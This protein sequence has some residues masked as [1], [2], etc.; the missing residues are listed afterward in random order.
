VLKAPLL[1]VGARTTYLLGPKLE[2][3]VATEPDEAFPR[4]LSVHSHS[5]Y[6]QTWFELGLVGATLLTLLGLAISQA[7]RSLARPIQPYAYATFVSAVVMAAS[8]Y[9]MWQT[10]F[11]SLFGITAAMFALGVALL[12]GRRSGEAAAAR[13]SERE[14]AVG[15]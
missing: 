11:V 6:L 8:S 1:G 10:W 2:A 7:I 3:A 5:V 14:A 9:G 13:T 12:T 15:A 4:T